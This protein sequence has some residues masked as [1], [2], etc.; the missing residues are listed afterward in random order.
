MLRVDITR[1][2]TF[3]ILSSSFLPR[4]LLPAAAPK[5]LA[6][7]VTDNRAV[8]PLLPAHD[9]P[10]ALLHRRAAVAAAVVV[11]WKARVRPRP[12]TIESMASGRCK[13]PDNRDRLVIA[14][15]VLDGPVCINRGEQAGTPHPTREGG[16]DKRLSPPWRIVFDSPARS[17]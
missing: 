12:P 6:L 15:N 4:P 5:A 9:G 13:P 8:C 14:S 1:G 11:T 16:D 7:L 3:T 10:A 2:L 17:R